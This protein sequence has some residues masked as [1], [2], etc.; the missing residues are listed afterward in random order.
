MTTPA[1]SGTLVVRDNDTLGREFHNLGPADLVLGRIR[2]KPSEEFM[3]LDLLERGVRLF[4]SALAQQACRSKVFQALLFAPFMLP[5]T[6]GIHD[7]HDMLAAVNL[8]DRKKISRVITK[9][10]RKNAGLGIHLWAGVEDVYNQ[11]SLGILP[12]P[13]VLQPFRPDSHDIRVIILAD[14]LEAYERDNPH[15]FRNN[16]HCGGRSRPCEL[17][18][19]QLQLCR[20]VMARGKFPYAHLDLMVKGSETFLAEIN[21]RGGIRGAKITPAEYKGRIE[22]IHDRA[23]SLT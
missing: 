5:H 4:P 15:N 6:L 8:Y 23:A 3:L 20:N 19:E 18:P 21:L 1:P 12:F 16:L 9:L 13:F 17:M 2:L 11:A 14:Y 22:A 10:D 7:R